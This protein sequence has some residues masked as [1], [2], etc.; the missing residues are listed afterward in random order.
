MR[1]PRLQLAILLGILLIA[2]AARAQWL[3]RAG[4]GVGQLVSPVA[5]G[6]ATTGE[7][8]GGIVRSLFGITRLSSRVRALEY[9]IAKLR[10]EETRA[11]SI[12][13][14]NA[15]LREALT[16]LP[17]DRFTLVSA[18]VTGPSTDGLSGTLRV[19]RGYRDGVAEGQAVIAADGVVVGKIASADANS[20][21][22]DVITSGRV[23][24]TARTLRTGAEGLVR[25]LRGLDVI[26]ENVPRTSELTPLDRLVT[27]GTDGIFP[28]HLFIGTVKSV[29][30]PE[31][32]IFQE[33][34][35]QLPLDLHRVRIVGVI[36]GKEP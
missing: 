35:V 22:V 1:P 27:L 9:E 32:A 6:A 2:L 16:L 28:P 3:R 23:R 24:L 12:E 18:D 11:A 34:S 26:I 17:R 5:D 30:S 15:E 31:N 29:R 21:L 20:S 33:A 36:V 13:R 19:N 4:D 10:A 8:S 7:V 25:G 14:E